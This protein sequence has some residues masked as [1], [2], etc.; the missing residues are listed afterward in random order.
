MLIYH[1]GNDTK[2]AI[3]QS[4]ESMDKNKKLFLNRLNW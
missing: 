3:K 4:Q 1:C 2:S